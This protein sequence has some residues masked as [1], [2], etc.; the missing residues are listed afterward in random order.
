MS[1]NIV[2]C[3]S[4]ASRLPRRNKG[5]PY[6]GFTS[7]SRRILTL[8]EILDSPSYPAKDALELNNVGPAFLHALIAAARGD[9][10]GD[11]EKTKGDA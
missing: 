2:H 1:L 7:P 4:C 10:P 6:C 11:G 9:L 8:R 3:P 5:C